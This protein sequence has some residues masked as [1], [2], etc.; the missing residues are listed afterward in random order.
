VLCGLTTVLL[1]EN[2]LLIGATYVAFPFVPALLASRRSAATLIELWSLLVTGT[3]VGM[4]ASVVIHPMYR[5]SE[6]NLWPFEIATF[7]GVGPVPAWVGLFVGR[8]LTRRTTDRPS[9]GRS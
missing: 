3:A 5:G 2:V 7:L 4:Y 6:R 1:P 9:I 8:R